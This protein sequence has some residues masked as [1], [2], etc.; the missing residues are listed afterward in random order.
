MNPLVFATLVPLAC[1]LAPAPSAPPLD[2]PV[3]EVPAPA[4]T[5]TASGMHIWSTDYALDRRTFRTRLLVHAASPQEGDMPTPP[6]G[7]EQLTYES[8]GRQL[9]AWVGRPDGVA[10]PAPVVVFL[11]GGFAF[12]AEDFEMARPFIRAGFTVVTPVLRGE[13]GLPGDFSMFYDE[14]DDVLAVTEHVRR[15][16]WADPDRM[17]VAGHSA[18]G[19]MTMLV[20]AS[21]TAFRAAVSFSG[22]ADQKTFTSGDPWRRIVPFDASDPRE[23]E[24][25]SLLTHP[26]SLKA[27][28]RF[29]Y[30]SEES[31]FRAE[32][33][34]L[35]GLAL[36]AGR[37]VGAATFP[38]DHF[39]AVP[40]ETEAAIAFF[41]QHM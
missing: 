10:G 41:R 28:I 16:P 35:V 33:E 12:A 38:G 34:E 2:G 1:S 21:T 20:A 17:F 7:V 11:H 27:P 15:Q 26:G 30:G 13:D 23:V 31:Y 4:V 24:M 25:R 3:P 37:D 40:A 39:S 18:G 6:V 9:T 14:V 5:R 32:T 19:T 36:A 29:F 22:S 8:S